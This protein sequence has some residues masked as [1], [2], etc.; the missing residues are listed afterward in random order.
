MN[1]W[2]VALGGDEKVFYGIAIAS[3]LVMGIQ[4]VLSLIGGAFDAPDGEFEV[5][6]TD[7][8]LGVLSIRTISSFF[9][10]FGWGGITAMN[11]YQDHPS[12]MT[13]ATVAAVVTGLI[14]LWAVWKTMKGLHSLKDDGTVDIK[15]AVGK[16]GMV[17]IP[18]HPRREG[19]GQVQV[20]VQG[21]ERVVLAL[22]DSETTIENRERVM[23]LEKI[24]GQTI[25][26]GPLQTSE[27][28]PA[29]EKESPGTGEAGNEK[30]S[31]N[32][33]GKE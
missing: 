23:V 31:E 12:K 18:V 14:F 15:N 9:V 29:A 27:G 11:I 32:E 1:D 24:D 28:S 3:S 22:T 8:D 33:E 20:K 13:I 30:S 2:W 6:G 5:E 10:G 26:V 21:R 4:L 16:V 7:G 17:Y 25:L 19:G